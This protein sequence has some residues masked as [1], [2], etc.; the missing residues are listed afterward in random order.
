MFTAARSAGVSEIEITDGESF[1]TVV[2]ATNLLGYTY[3]LRS[4]GITIKLEPPLPGVVR[5]GDMVGVDL[6]YQASLHKLSANWDG[7][8]GTWEESDTPHGN[9]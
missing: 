6:G 5:D 9:L 1:F 8:G 2:T 4:D 7:F 3:S